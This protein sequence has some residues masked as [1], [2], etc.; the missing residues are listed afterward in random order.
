MVLVQ[1]VHVLVDPGLSLYHESAL[2]TSLLHSHQFA[3]ES[4]LDEQLLLATLVDLFGAAIPEHKL[5]R[6]SDKLVASVFDVIQITAY[7]LQS[8]KYIRVVAVDAIEMCLQPL[9]VVID[10]QVATLLQG[11]G[12]VAVRMGVNCRV[13]LVHDLMSKVHL[14]LV[15]FR[16]DDLQELRL[17]VLLRV[18]VELERV[19]EVME[20]LGVC[21]HK[22]VHKDEDGII[23]PEVGRQVVHIELRRYVGLDSL[24]YL[25]HKELLG[26]LDLHE[27]ALDKQGSF[28]SP[29]VD[30]YLALVMQHRK[31]VL[32]L[33]EPQDSGFSL[34]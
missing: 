28:H 22:L 18:E 13:Y 1:L 20:L 3:E 8:L 14:L 31:L 10:G 29:H 5:P 2:L 27:S 16:T 33:V 26:Q 30:E 7:S 24:L 25:K 34:T 17:E 4:G 12:V 15:L 21:R 11:N 9:Y 6:G 23:V 32:F 19:P